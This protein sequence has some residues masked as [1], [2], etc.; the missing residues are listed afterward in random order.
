VSSKKA[1]ALTFDE[2]NRLRELMMIQNKY[3]KYRYIGDKEAYRNYR[4]LAGEQES[5]N[6]RTRSHQ[7]YHVPP[8]YTQ[9]VPA[10][11]QLVSRQALA[12]GPR[13][14][15]QSYSPNDPGIPIAELL[16]MKNTPS[17][18]TRQGFA[19][20]GAADDLVAQA[21]WFKDPV[22]R[23]LGMT[24][25][26]EVQKRPSNF[27]KRLRDVQGL[28]EDRRPQKAHGGRVLGELTEA[29][30]ASHAEVRYAAHSS[31]KKQRCDLCTKFISAEKGGSACKKIQSPIA[32]SGWC[33]RFVMK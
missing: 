8:W 33:I 11:Q 1:K 2:I 30:K 19:D 31:H 23:K 14:A 27:A 3:N 10:N 25:T 13:R 16:G 5:E 15:Y 26:D 24:G 4:N 7:G 12:T 17:G 29:N 21:S 6:V 18:G 22:A 28:V 32:A 9:E 20:G